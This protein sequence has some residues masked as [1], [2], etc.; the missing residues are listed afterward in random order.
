MGAFFMGKAKL[1]RNVSKLLPQQ[2]FD[3][4]VNFQSLQISNQF[5]GNTNQKAR[6]VRRSRLSKE[7]SKAY[8]EYGKNYIKQNGSLNGH[9][10]VNYNGDE[11]DLKSNSK[12]LKDGS[13]SLKARSNATKEA[14]T[15]KR[16]RMEQEQTFGTDEWK[17]GHHRVQLDLLERLLEGLPDLQRK[18]FV[19]LLNTQF[20]SI[21]TGNGSQNIIPLPDKVHRGVHYKLAEAGLD[22][23]KMNFN[24]VSF[25]DRL[26]FMREVEVI[27]LDIDKYISQGLQDQS[28]QIL[29]KK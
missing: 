14:Q 26:K 6:R 24:G 25:K 3:P 19:K 20:S 16:D 10:K 13:P 17:P 5:K 8:R 18:R 12:P 15:N 4:N 23:K 21:T 11:F 1:V 2:R 29:S 22:P 7:D 27:L 9:M 28:D